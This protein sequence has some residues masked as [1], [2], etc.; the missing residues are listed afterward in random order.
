MGAKFLLVLLLLPQVFALDAQAGPYQI[1]FTTQPEYTQPQQPVQLHIQILKDE[2]ILHDFAAEIE[3][4]QQDSLIYR[5]AGTY[6]TS[7]LVIPYQFAAPGDYELRL[8]MPDTPITKI[9][10]TIGTAVPEQPSSVL[11]WVA[12]FLLAVILLM[13]WMAFRRDRR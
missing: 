1:T 11:N 10:F 12:L 5:V 6:P 3:I 2:Q 13:L 9:P 8:S 7:A 4:Y